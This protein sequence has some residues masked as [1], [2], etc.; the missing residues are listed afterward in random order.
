MTRPV[1]RLTQPA[2]AVRLCVVCVSVSCAA[3]LK[4]AK[5]A[6]HAYSCGSYYYACID[7]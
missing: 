3:T 2:A 1:R 4:K 5:V 6:Q 7:W